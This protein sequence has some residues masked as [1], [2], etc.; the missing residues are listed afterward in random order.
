MATN[1]GIDFFTG[2]PLEDFLDVAKEVAEI[3]K[4]NNIRTSARNRR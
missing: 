3:G 4:Q 2:L 1:T